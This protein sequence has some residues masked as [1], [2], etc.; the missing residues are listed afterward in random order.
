M[1]TVETT[2]TDI[3]IVIKLPWDKI[4]VRQALPSLFISLFS[5]SALLGAILLATLAVQSFIIGALTVVGLG[6]FFQNLL[7]VLIVLLVLAWLGYML[8]L[9]LQYQQTIYTLEAPR[10]KIVGENPP[11]EHPAKLIIQTGLFW[12]RVSVYPLNGYDQA[13]VKQAPW[14]LWLGYGDLIISDSRQLIPEPQ[15]IAIENIR[16]PAKLLLTVQEL[17]ESK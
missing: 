6:I 3:K 7:S 17:L 4:L 8:L 16:N 14:E 10:Q 2:T 13:H 9:L 12:K 11:E 5:Y 1:P 15:T